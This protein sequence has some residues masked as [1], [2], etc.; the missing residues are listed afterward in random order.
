MLRLPPFPH[1]MPTIR[2]PHL[3]PYPSLQFHIAYHAHY[4]TTPSQYASNTATPCLP[5]HSL[6]LTMLTLLKH[7]QDMPLTLSPHVCPHPSSCFHTPTSSS[8]KITI[9]M[10]PHYINRVRWLVGINDGPHYKN[11][12]SG[13]L[14]KHPL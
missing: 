4:P 7:P 1:Y 2:P 12:L 5:P 8:Q 14:H 10:L 6:G 13:L 9:L 3:Q 11:I